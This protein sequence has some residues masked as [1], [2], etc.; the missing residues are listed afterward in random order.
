MFTKK[1][2]KK[3]KK[4]RTIEEGVEHDCIARVQIQMSYIFQYS[5]DLKIGRSVAHQNAFSERGG[6]TI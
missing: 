3:E 1:K 2:K 4:R 6:K 5:C